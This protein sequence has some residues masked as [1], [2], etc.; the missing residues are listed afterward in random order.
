MQARVV[1]SN[2]P[3]YHYQEVWGQ[4]YGQPT[5]DSYPIK[6]WIGHTTDQRT[7]TH[8]TV[9]SETEAGLYYIS[10]DFIFRAGMFRLR[11]DARSWL[12]ECP[13]R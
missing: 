8:T 4:Q 6:F 1:Y 12:T 7:G 5:N 9:F 11:Y 10:N 2:W 13:V 3:G